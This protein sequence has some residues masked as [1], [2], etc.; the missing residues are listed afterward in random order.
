MIGKLYGIGVGPGDP[1]LLTVKAFRRL[2]EVAVIAYPKKTNGSKSYAQQIVEAYFS[3]SEKHMLGLVFPMTKD[4]NVLREKWDETVDNVWEH[5]REGKHVAFVTEGD[6]LLYSTCI[7]FMRTMQMKYP[8]VSIEIVPGV[9]SI[10]GAAARLQLPLAD[11]DETIA[12]VPARD[13]YDAM[14][15]AIE[16]HDCVIFLKV[17]K[18]MPLLLSILKEMNLTKKAAVVTKVTSHEEVIWDIEQ[19]DHVSLPYLTLMVVRK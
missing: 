8:D 3:P 7:H 11:G 13:D 18:V 17:A 9:S 12:I 19:L 10:N 4:E 16:A 6:P 14:K 5:L 15:K 2:K 1:E